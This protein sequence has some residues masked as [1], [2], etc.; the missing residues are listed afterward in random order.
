M[1]PDFNAQLARQLRFLETS[2]RQF[3][4]GQPDEAIR[5]ATALRVIF[6]NTAASR[7]LLAHLNAT[8]VP[9]LSTCRRTRMDN[10][11]GFWPGLVQI[12]IDV[13][14]VTVT[15]RPKFDATPGGHRMVPFRT[16]WEGEVVYF[17]AGR[18]IRRNRLVLD[19]ANKD[20][21]AH[22]DASLPADY[23]WMVAGC[24]FSFSRETPAGER[25]ESWLAYP[26]LSC[27]R[28]MAYEVF[29]S[30]SLLTLAR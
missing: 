17:G 5:I 26:H 11:N 10:P 3:D 18:T 13:K 7:S 1:K 9:I 22:V 8:T 12:L 24:G 30:P 2:C 27:L 19:A 29:N 21:G 4:A 25:T 6:H 28:Q 15:S 23:G 14:H 20:G 16:W